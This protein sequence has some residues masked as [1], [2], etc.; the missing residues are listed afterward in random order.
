LFTC[1]CGVTCCVVGAW[2]FTRRKVGNDRVSAWLALNPALGFWQLHSFRSSRPFPYTTTHLP[3]GL[4]SS[5]LGICLILQ[6]EVELVL[7]WVRRC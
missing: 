5:V 6:L 2:A 4:L 7:H 1:G 3:A